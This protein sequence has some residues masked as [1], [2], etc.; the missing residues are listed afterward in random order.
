M[1]LQTL[2]D[3]LP[4]FAKDAK[5]NLSSILTPEG[6]PGLTEKQIF[7]VALACAF[8]TKNTALVLAI[9]QSAQQFL[10]PEEL[11]AAAVA[12]TTMA[13]TNIYYRFL[14]LAGDD[15]FSKMPARLRMNALAKPGAPKI[16]FELATLA[17]SV[18][19]G[20]EKCVQSHIHE[21]RTAGM[22]NEGIQSAVRIASTINSVAMAL[23]INE[24]IS[25]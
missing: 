13:M 24:N 1:N 10:T 17:V 20:C 11:N 22:G 4:E 23:T 15:T 18:L 16:D 8:S 21:L 5:L 3:S 12:S 14:H 19:E 7:L 9:K 6:A 25:N 2:K